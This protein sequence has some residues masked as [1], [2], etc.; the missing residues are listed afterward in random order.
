[1]KFPLLCIAACLLVNQS[2]FAAPGDTPVAGGEF[3]KTL[4]RIAFGSCSR[5]SDPQPV[6]NQVLQSKP[7]LFIYLGDNIYGNSDDVAVI[8]EKYA[9]LGNKAE[10]KALRNVTDV[11]ATWD[12]HDYGKN[13]AGRHFWFKEKSKELFLEFWREPVKSA[14]RT[15][16]GVYADYMFGDR[17]RRVQIILLDTRTF[18]DDLKH[19]LMRVR[20]SKG[21]A[22]R[23]RIVAHSDTSMTILGDTQWRWLEEQLR[24]PA[25]LRIIG[26][27]IQF[28]VTRNGNEGWANFPHEQQK[29]IDLIATTR[30]TGLV[31][32]SGD[33]H[34]AETSLLKTDNTYALYDFT[35]SGISKKIPLAPPNSNR[36]DGPVKDNN[37]GLLEIDWNKNAIRFKVIDVDGKERI[38]RPVSLDKLTFK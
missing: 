24:K 4:T 28:G 35:S 9:R 32:I 20:K 33:V 29:F 22:Y 38:N 27:S 11:I 2:L 3:S 25:D 13:N 8:R 21:S 5:E 10:F 6:L 1:M 30:A 19:R 23:R 16:K 34:Y 15:H 17:G 36:I 7:D 14:R 12:D 31:F 37:Y 26:S 18:R